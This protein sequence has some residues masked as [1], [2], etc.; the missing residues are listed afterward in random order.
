MATT[1]MQYYKLSY[2]QALKLTFCMFT[3]VNIMTG[4]WELLR[5]HWNHAKPQNNQHEI[6]YSL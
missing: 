1:V 4:N 6:V 5:T 3:H 2:H